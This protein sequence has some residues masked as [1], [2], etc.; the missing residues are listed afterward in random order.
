MSHLPHWRRECRECGRALHDG[1]RLLCVGCSVERPLSPPD[2][3]E[4]SWLDPDVEFRR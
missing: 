1:E 4:S 3:C 2:E